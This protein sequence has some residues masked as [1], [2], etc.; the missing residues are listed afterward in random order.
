M[1]SWG[2]V[3]F[4]INGIIRRNRAKWGGALD[5]WTYSVLFDFVDFG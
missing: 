5:G 4:A 2:G 3:G 1:T